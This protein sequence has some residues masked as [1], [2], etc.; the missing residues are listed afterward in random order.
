MSAQAS[1]GELLLDGKLNT[2]ITPEQRA[3]F[4]LHR[5]LAEWVA[6]IEGVD[7]YI[8]THSHS[9]A[10][11]HKDKSSVSTDNPHVRMDMYRLDV[12]QL[13]K[14]VSASGGALVFFAER[15]KASTS[16][17]ALPSYASHPFGKYVE[18][19]HRK[20]V[21]STDVEVSQEQNAKIHFHKVTDWNNDVYDPVRVRY[22]VLQELAALVFL[23]NVYASSTNNLAALFDGVSQDQ[24]HIVVNENDTTEKLEVEACCADFKR[25]DDTTLRLLMTRHK[26]EGKKWMRPMDSSKVPTVV[27]AAASAAAPK[28]DPKT[29]IVPSHPVPP[30]VA[31]AAPVVAAAATVVV[32]AATAAAAAAAAAQSVAPKAEQPV[33]V[34]G[35]AKASAPAPAPAH[36]Q[37]GKKRKTT[38]SA[39]EQ[40][41]P[42]SVAAPAP[43]ATAAPATASAAAPTQPQPQPDRRVKFKSDSDYWDAGQQ[44]MKAY[45]ESVH[46][47]LKSANN[48]RVDA[49]LVVGTLLNH[50]ARLVGPDV[51]LKAIFST[52]MHDKS[53][54]QDVAQLAN[55]CFQ[56]HI[57]PRGQTMGVTPP[58]PEAAA[59]AAM[60]PPAARI[61]GVLLTAAQP[62]Q[63]QG[64]STNSNG[65]T[66]AEIARAAR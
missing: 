33:H 62:L 58:E 42:P 30:V 36:K 5:V 65:Q 15:L 4:R 41:A 16:D 8:G 40:T 60:P 57:E 11:P 46:K 7:I 14:F 13:K 38:D 50:A 9:S 61:N 47:E 31:V 6:Q 22:L 59:R 24:V 37:P 19:V 45:I 43:V 3:K 32:A 49:L 26:E 28:A 21:E 17:K 18:A 1:T 52:Y 39:T 51:M 23:K 20:R 12:E 10:F 63:P 66:A 54:D 34:D 53:G 64:P 56:Y 48:S 44:V 29:S 35:A 27:G 25:K 55:M 2:E